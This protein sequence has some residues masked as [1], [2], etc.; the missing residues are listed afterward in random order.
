MMKKQP[1]QKGK[2]M[3]RRD[4][5]KGSAMSAASF[6]IVPRNVIGG[7]GYTA[8]SDTV[9]VAAIGAGGMGASNMSRLT[10]QN[11]VALADCDHDWVKKSVSRDNRSE[12]RAAYEKATWYYDFREMLENQKDIDAVVVATPDHVHAAAA[13]MAMKMGKHVYVQKPLTY[14]VHE[15]RA[16]RKTAKET[17][18]VTQMGNQ[19]HSSD[20]AR[21]VNEWIQA[22]AIGPVREVHVWTNRPIWPQG[23]DRPEGKS[24]KPKNLDWDVFLGPA[25]YVEYNPAYHPFAWRGWTDYGVGALGDM[26]AHLIDHPYWALG[27]D[28]PDTVEASSTPWG[29]KDDSKV[30]YPLSTHVHYTFPARGMYPEVDMFWYDGGIMPARPSVLPDEVKL[31]RGGGVIFVGEKGILMHETYGSNPQMYPQ[32]LM[33]EYADTP[34][35]YE[36]IKGGRDAHEMNWIRAIKGEEKACSPFDYAAP[37]TETML[38]GVVA[39]HAPGE[40]LRYD[41]EK[42]QFTNNQEVNRYLQR[43]Y[44]DGWTLS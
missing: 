10:S 35:T 14:T 20:D 5:L 38:L 26:G 23:M 43:E 28:Y 29:G 15:A 22:G 44:R 12:L 17:G 1:N 3:Q 19:G 39:L 9:N 2:P 24:K 13:N 41:S 4:F 31:D 16:L 33:K 34:Q 25:P 18:V 42:M 7:K 37:L 32:S 6:M 36:R 11:I 21:R 27:L 30:A 40:T 8:P